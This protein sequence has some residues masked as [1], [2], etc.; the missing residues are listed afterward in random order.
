MLLMR[1][2]SVS[3]CSS[4]GGPP[5]QRIAH[6]GLGHAET[7]RQL[8]VAGAAYARPVRSADRAHL[9]VS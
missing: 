1:A 8:T 4:I 9:I 6:G 7:A 2:I 5:G 3:N